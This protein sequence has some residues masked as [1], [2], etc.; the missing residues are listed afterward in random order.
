MGR[1]RQCLCWWPACVAL[2]AAL[3]P[4]TTTAATEVTREAEKIT[5]ALKPDVTPAMTAA[6]RQVLAELQRQA[7]TLKADFLNPLP[8]WSEATR[9]E[10]DAALTGTFTLQ[11]VTGSAPR[12]ADGG[13]D[14]TWRGPNDDPEFAWFLNRQHHIPALFVAWRET[15]DARYRT[16]LNAQLRDWLRQSPR[17]GHY[18]FSSAWRALE[19]AR[20]M[21]EAWM[22]VLLAPQ[23]DAALDDDV[24]AGM[25][26]DIPEHAIALR[27]THSFSGNHLITE[28]TGL[29]AIALAFPEF[30]DAPQWLDYAVTQARTEAV[31]EIYPD[32]AETE[33]SNWYQQVVLL[34]L[35]RLV[36]MLSSAGRDKELSKLRPL[37][38]KGWNFFAHTLSPLGHGPLD[39]DSSVGNDAGLVRALAA[40]YHRADWLYIATQGQEGTA[41][42]GSA[43]EYF[44]YA[45]LA[46][47]RSGWDAN[48]Q[49]AYFDLGP[50]GSDHQHADRLHLSIGGG[51]REFLVD[52]GR[53]NYQPG[54][55]R[56]YF[57]GPQGHNVV[58]LDGQG[59]L[60]PPETVSTP[61][62][63]HHEIAPDRDYFAATAPFA[64]S[65][66]HGQGPAYHTRSVEYIPGKYWVITDEIRCVG[67]H[68]VEV[69]W[70]F[71]PECM[72]KMEGNLIY[73][74]DPGKANIGLLAVETPAQIWNIDTLRGRE[75]PTPQGWYSPQ[76]NQR[77][78]A[79][80][81][82]F[83]TLIHQPTTFTW[84]IWIVPPGQD[85]RP[86]R[87]QVGARN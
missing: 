10:A 27:D 71:H 70:H 49:W 25:L 16:A 45:G 75:T 63:T 83:S 85:V 8:G 30:K 20:R 24:L 81:A 74:D 17:P 34:E 26:A 72:V 60:R 68:K 84:V 44:P 31:K 4:A 43:S 28:M 40:K 69:L 77:V 59:T 39:N 19:V 5:P 1:Y 46:V 73:T 62:E 51:G 36:D 47:M 79:T 76:F 13:F 9:Q 2:A 38:E 35:Q 12:R 52:D 56:D 23:A 41:P 50:Y 67:P 11:G 48:A 22:P 64:G 54:P 21:E 3:L 57:T 33:L 78:A 82:V 66:L 53:Y 37:V 87:P 80:C 14:W 55:W 65:G 42:A 15:K 29:A 6:P 61:V 18:S 32:G 7:Q 58:L 86:E